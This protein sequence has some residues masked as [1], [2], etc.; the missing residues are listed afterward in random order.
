MSVFLRCIFYLLNSP[1]F[2]VF[3]Y[4]SLSL[5]V[6]VLFLSL[7][8]TSCFISAY[9]APQVTLLF[10][11]LFLHQMLWLPLVLT[12]IF[13][14]ASPLVFVHKHEEKQSVKSSS[15]AKIKIPGCSRIELLK[16]LF[17]D[18]V[19][20]LVSFIV[21]FFCVCGL[22]P[23]LLTKKKNHFYCYTKKYKSPHVCVLFFWLL[24]IYP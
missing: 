21:G 18:I 4:L 11:I 20:Y 12:F 8:S 14:F 22:C 23:F 5:W 9:F 2:S 3:T 16:V 19:I 6:P 13:T 1:Q 24:F 17:I 15:K 7:S 10:I